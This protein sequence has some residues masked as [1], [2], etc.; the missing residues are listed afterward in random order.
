MA[1]GVCVSPPL[2]AT[3]KVVNERD[4]GVVR[5]IGGL[6]RDAS[7]INATTQLEA[8]CGPLLRTEVSSFF[9]AL[10]GHF[11]DRFFPRRLS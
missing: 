4:K 7:E 10:N 8:A 2:T 3:E 6:S 9:M 11:F 5:F 1:L